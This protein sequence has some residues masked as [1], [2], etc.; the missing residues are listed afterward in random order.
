MKVAT[1]DRGEIIHFAGFHRL[2]PALRDGLPTFV[3]G[4]DATATRCGWEAFFRAMADRRLA[5]GFDPEDGTSAQFRPEGDLR[6][7]PPPHRQR[8]GALAHAK[9][10]LRALLPPPSGAAPR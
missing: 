10:F 6:D 5:M 3:A 7:L 4:P 8:E 9:R 1:R 2:S